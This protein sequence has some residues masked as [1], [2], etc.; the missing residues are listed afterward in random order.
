M[1]RHLG[2]AKK[3]ADVQ[4]LGL[5][6][7]TATSHHAD[8][9]DRERRQ[10]EGNFLQLDL[11]ER[12]EQGAARSARRCRDGHHQT[13]RHPA[14][15]EG[16]PRVVGWSWRFLG[17]V[18]ST[19]V[20]FGALSSAVM[21]TDRDGFP[22]PLASR[23]RARELRCHRCH[24]S[25]GRWSHVHA[26]A[27]YPT[28]TPPTGDGTGLTGSKPCFI[29]S[30]RLS[31]TSVTSVT[32]LVRGVT[33][34]T[35]VSDTEASTRSGSPGPTGRTSGTPLPSRRQYERCRASRRT[36]ST[37]WPDRVH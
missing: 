3:T 33:D 6:T 9:L 19:P 16:V 28:S 24:R 36:A 18:D 11:V 4:H 32:V 34:V 37:A 17:L 25:V 29:A 2:L 27:I 23:S 7:K 26:C 14:G 12:G 31:D 8:D 35:L 21:L 5:G 20:R 30:V 22:A 13:E 1:S 15:V 10:R